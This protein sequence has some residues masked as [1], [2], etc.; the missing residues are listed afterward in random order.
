MKLRT[1]W[2]DLITNQRQLKR[3][4][5]N[6]KL[7]EKTQKKLR[8]KNE[9]KIK[10]QVADIEQRLSNLTVHTSHLGVVLKFRF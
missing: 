5:V 10:E 4:L 7:D 3:E 1:Q 9:W 8:K 6:W 2:I